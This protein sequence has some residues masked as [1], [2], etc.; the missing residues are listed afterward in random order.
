RTFF[1]SSES[2]VAYEF[3]A[4]LTDF[5]ISVV[6]QRSFRGEAELAKM[7]GRLGWI[8]ER[9]GCC[10]VKFK[11]ARLRQRGAAAA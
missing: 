10:R 11:K 1:S 9:Q 7:Y 8:G 2:S 5:G 4:T 3:T 6:F